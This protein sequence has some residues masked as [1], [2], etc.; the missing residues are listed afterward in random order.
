MSKKLMKSL[1]DAKNKI[2]EIQNKTSNISLTK[3]IFANKNMSR[4]LK[5]KKFIKKG[6]TTFKKKIDFQK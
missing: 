3:S 5:N 6:I 4:L 1:L 2:T